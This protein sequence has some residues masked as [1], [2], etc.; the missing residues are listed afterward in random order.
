MERMEEEGRLQML[1]CFHIY[2]HIFTFAQVL[3]KSRK[4]SN[5]GHFKTIQTLRGGD[6]V[7]G[8]DSLSTSQ[9]P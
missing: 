1:T 2:I 6:R 8:E 9:L 5:N 3:R 4:F 7:L